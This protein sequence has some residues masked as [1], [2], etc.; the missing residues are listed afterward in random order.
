MLKR[1]LAPLE[2]TRK[3]S[4]LNHVVPREVDSTYPV[5]QELT[6]QKVGAVMHQRQNTD[7]SGKN[8]VQLITDKKTKMD[9]LQRKP[10]DCFRKGVAGE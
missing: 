5:A 2:N 3:C 7:G 1:E 8:S 4:G 10:W 9:E 6:G